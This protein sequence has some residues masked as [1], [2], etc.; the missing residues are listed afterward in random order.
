[1]A[2][3]SSKGRVRECVVPRIELVVDLERGRVTSH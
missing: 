3:L 1:M 2:D